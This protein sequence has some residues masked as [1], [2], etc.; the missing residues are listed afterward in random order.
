[1]STIAIDP[2]VHRR[3]LELKEEL[4]APSLNEVV[5]QLLD[6]RRPVPASMFGADPALRRLDRKTRDELWS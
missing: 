2:A 1:M 4:A 6:R 3:L 5:R